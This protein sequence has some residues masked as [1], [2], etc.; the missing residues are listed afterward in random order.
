[1]RKLNIYSYTQNI[2]HIGQF[3]VCFSV[4]HPPMLKQDRGMRRTKKVYDK[5]V[6]IS[7][8]VALS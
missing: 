7:I 1:M 2:E 3:I 5:N 8:N 4:A 6:K